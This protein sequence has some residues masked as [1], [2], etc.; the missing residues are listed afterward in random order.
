MNLTWFREN[1]GPAQPDSLVI[2][3]QFNKTVTATSTLLVDVQDW[4]EGE[5]YYCKVTHPDLPR[6]ILRSISKAPGKRLAPEV[7]VLSPR[8]E[9]RAAKD[10]LTLTCLAQNF[11]PEDI[12]VQ[13]LRNKALI[14]TD[15]H[16][17]TKPH[18]ANG[19]SPAFF[20]YSRLVVSQA[21]WEQKN[22]FTCR[23]VHEALPGSRTLEKSVSSDLGK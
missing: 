23:V 2:K 12:S 18:K 14:Q 5:T 7:Y 6:S 13:W 3:T 1:R 21:D 22:K 20:V 15:Q 16:S 4:I 11:F 9:E 19:P 17:T 10:K 8:K